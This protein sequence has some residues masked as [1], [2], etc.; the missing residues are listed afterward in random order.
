MD[1]LPQS[2]NGP[3]KLKKV[4]DL[5][6]VTQKTQK[7]KNKKKYKRKKKKN[8]KFGKE[9]QNRGDLVYVRKEE[10]QKDCNTA[11][12]DKTKEEKG[13]KGKET[14]FT[15]NE[16]KIQHGIKEVFVHQGIRNGFETKKKEISELSPNTKKKLEECCSH[17][18]NPQNV[19]VYK[20]RITLFLLKKDPSRKISPTFLSHQKNI[21]EK[22]RGI[23]V[24]WLVDVSLR[25]GLLDE[26]LFSAIWIMDRYLSKEESLSKNLL[27]LLGVSC[28]MI[29]AKMEEVYPPSLKDYL[30]VCDGAYSE[31][32]IL[33]KEA[34]ILSVLQFDIAVATSL[35]MYK[36]FTRGIFL[37][38]KSYFFGEYLLH[39]SLLDIRAFKFSQNEL[40]AGAIFLVNKMFKG[41]IKWERDLSEIAGV[42]VD[43][44]KVV[45]KELYKILKRI[46]EKDWEA[47]RRKFSRVEVLEVAKFKVER[48]SKS[49]KK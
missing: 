5:A 49:K 21:S 10:K 42:S 18:I 20:K 44:A 24:D 35:H 30:K 33:D 9:L 36:F 46:G 40:S 2:N 37:A 15:K 38:Q 4:K 43:K 32:Q 28:L 8:R 23:L 27:Q 39:S 47:V 31:N 14:K 6:L 17:R 25:F 22:M 1:T 12:T 48:V 34:R 19:E 11:D 45:A 13:R 3:F 7:P 16:V 41:K 29:S 26:T